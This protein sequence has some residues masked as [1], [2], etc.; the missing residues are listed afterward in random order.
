MKTLMIDPPSGWRYGF[1]KPVP[2]KVL[3]NEERLVIWL[4][5]QGYPEKEIPLAVEYSRYWE[6]EE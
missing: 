6:V 1:P 3:K 4:I 2:Q 5:E